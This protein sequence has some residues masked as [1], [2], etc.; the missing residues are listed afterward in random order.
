MAR[1]K[2]LS[3]LVAKTTA[4]V[5][6][7]SQLSADCTNCLKVVN[8]TITNGRSWLCTNGPQPAPMAQ[9]L[10]HRLM[11][12]YRLNPERVFNDPMGRCKATTPS[13]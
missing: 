10:C 9:W 7:Q 3:T 1:A 13:H 2:M 4:I 5:P 6:I 8:A 12:W 11:G